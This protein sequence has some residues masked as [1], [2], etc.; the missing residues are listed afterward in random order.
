MTR[1]HALVRSDDIG[2]LTP[3]GRDQMRAYGV[4]TV[5]DLRAQSELDGTFDPRFPR[6]AGDRVRV[7]GVEYVHRALVDDASLKRLGDAS[8]MYERYLLML[9]TRREAFRDIFLAIAE[10][11]GG[12]L[13]HCFAGKDRTGLVAA[14]IL[15]LAD[16]EADDIAADFAETDVQLA[17]QY[18]RWIQQTAPEK[19]DEM[20]DELRCPPDRILGV[21]DFLETKW[22]GVAS[23]LEAAGMTQ[24]SIDLV[25]AKLA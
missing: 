3:E 10:A 14:L 6:P 24:S 23:Y 19:R 5:V 4:T 16:V 8:N 15:E 17:R 1:A 20:R 12:V 9:D 22:G 21:L 13:F 18:E 11:E 2:S 7:S 25:R